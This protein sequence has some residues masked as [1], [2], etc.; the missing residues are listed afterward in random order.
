MA[1]NVNYPTI[2][3][4]ATGNSKALSTSVTAVIDIP[5]TSNGGKPSF[6]RV[7]VSNG[8]AYVRL[9]PTATSASTTL[10]TDTMVTVSDCQYFT[11]LGMTSVGMLM[12]AGGS[13]VVGQV[14]ALEE[15]SI[16]PSPGAGTMG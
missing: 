12:V 8:A 16:L 11:T 6:I 9:A 4:V 10:T 13:P 15:G 2:Q 5:R 7:A 3:V 1:M 14:S